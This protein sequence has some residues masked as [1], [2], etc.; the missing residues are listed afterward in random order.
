MVS[1]ADIPSLEDASCC[2]VDVVSGLLGC[3]LE[4]VSLMV[5]SES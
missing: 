3:F 4:I 2:S 5:V 1:V